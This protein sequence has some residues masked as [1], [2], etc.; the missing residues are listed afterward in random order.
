MSFFRFLGLE[1]KEP[2]GAGPETDSVRRIVDALD[3]MEPERARYLAAFAYVLARAARADLHISE[4]E[5]RMMERIVV[6]R[7]NLPADQ[8]VIVVQIA[9]TQNKLFGATE[10][11]LVA[12]E[13]NRIASREQKLALLDCLFAV[14]AAEAMISLEE[15]REIRNIARELNLE[16]RDFI[17]VRSAWRD[18][19]SV[20]RK[21]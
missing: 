8:A 10:D 17:A 9:K 12:R 2:E 3:R 5:T 1:G 6:E 15:D 13:M 7:G 18:H 11:F 16:H 4:M 21:P 19:L 14:A 20:L